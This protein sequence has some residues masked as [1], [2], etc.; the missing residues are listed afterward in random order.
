MA[1]V[2]QWDCPHGVVD[3]ICVRCSV[4]VSGAGALWDIY[5]PRAR[6]WISQW[7]DAFKW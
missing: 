3:D 2:E 5:W 7:I 6:R 4:K 1:M